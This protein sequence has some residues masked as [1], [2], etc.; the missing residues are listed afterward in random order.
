MAVE[1]I[2]P[3]MTLTSN[4]YLPS[5]RVNLCN[6][7]QWFESELVIS[8]SNELIAV[9][10]QLEDIH[11]ILMEMKSLSNNFRYS[12]YRMSSDT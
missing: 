8:T 7:P 10:K 11:K 3:I 6:F 1:S 4:K 2:P 5:M 12:F 9:K